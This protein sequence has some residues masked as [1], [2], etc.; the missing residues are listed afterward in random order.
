[1]GCS[2]KLQAERN[3]KKHESYIAFLRKHY[4]TTYNIE[5]MVIAI[6]GFIIDEVANLR[7]IK[8]AG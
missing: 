1:M 4:G 8:K 3:I 2:K 5:E 7:N 6:S